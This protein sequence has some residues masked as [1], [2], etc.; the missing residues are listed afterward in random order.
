MQV[1]TQAAAL[2]TTNF[3][4]HV[5]DNFFNRTKRW[6]KL[7]LS[8]SQL[9]QQQAVVYFTGLS[10]RALRAW[11]SLILRVGTSL[12]HSIASLLP[13]YTSLA[14]PPP[15]A[16]AHA[17]ALVARMRMN[18]PG[19]P[20]TTDSIRANPH[21]YLPWMWDMLQDLE[22]LAAAHETGSK[23]F[24][25]APQC[26]NQTRFITISSTCLHRYALLWCV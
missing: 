9:P 18:I 16:M 7:Q 12:H 24:S 20:V 19:L 6:T 21:S 2:A 8:N 10:Q 11:S 4:N 25:M 17:Q 5:A 1:M 22:P 23:L 26:G 13:S 14:P 3:E 15:A